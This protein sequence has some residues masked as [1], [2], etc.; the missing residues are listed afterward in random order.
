VTSIRYRIVLKY[1]G[2]ALLILGVAF[3]LTASVSLALGEPSL[4]HYTIPGGCT[5]LAGW[6]LTWRVPEK[7][8]T[9]PEVAAIA[10]LSFFSQAL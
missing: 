8:V 9:T 4:T 5:V 10:C 7:E 2:G 3:I 6:Y 1:T